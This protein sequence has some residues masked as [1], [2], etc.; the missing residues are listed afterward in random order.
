MVTW[1]TTS[2][3]RGGSGS[4]ITTPVGL[5]PTAWPYAKSPTT[6]RDCQ[7]PRCTAPDTTWE[8]G[9]APC[10]FAPG[11]NSSNDCSA[12]LDRITLFFPDVQRMGLL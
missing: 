2:G 5:A 12:Q 6:G 8:C 7:V 4:A 1:V 10:L 9:A 3:A 11:G